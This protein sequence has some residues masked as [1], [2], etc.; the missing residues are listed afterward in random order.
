MKEA[1]G[2]SGTVCL[3]AGVLKN[4]IAILILRLHAHMIGW[5][6]QRVQITSRSE[7]GEECERRSAGTLS[8][9]LL[10]D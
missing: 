2:R 4:P 7:Q 9:V 8:Q 10:G 5:H 1:I 3:G 6:Y